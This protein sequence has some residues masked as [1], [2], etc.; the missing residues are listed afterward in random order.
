M[1]ISLDRLRLLLADVYGDVAKVMAG[2]LA[3]NGLRGVTKL[4]VAGF[5]GPRGL[6][7][8]RSV[9]AIFRLGEAL[10][11]FGLHYTVLSMVP[12]ASSREQ[13][14]E[15]DRI[16]KC[17]LLLRV[18]IA[19]AFLLAGAVFAGPIATSILGDPSLAGWVR[20]AFVAVMGQS[21]WKF[22]AGHLSAARE[23]GRVAF[24]Q[25]TTPFLMVGV[26]ATL[27]LAQAFDLTGAIVIYLFA[28]TV[29]VALWFPWVDRRFLRASWNAATTRRVIRFGRWA[30]LSRVSTASLG[31]INPLLLKNPQLSGS[32]AAGET[33]AGLYTFGNELADELTF[34]SESLY[35]VLLPRAGE[36]KSAGA[37][38]GFVTRCY[39]NLALLIVP[40]ILPIFLFKPFLL[41]LG[42]VRVGYLEF[43]PSYE[44][45]VILYASGLL[46]L[47]IIPMRSALYA[48]ELSRV[49][50]Y[51]EAAGAVLLIAGG[52]VLIP[53]YGTIGAAVTALVA[54]ALVLCALLAYGTVQL[55][56]HVTS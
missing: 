31:Q 54:R 35:L 36:K 53:T 33:N 55:R 44:V 45:F 37:L 41:L 49:D 38:R 43:L 40:L 8:L 32:L 27:L 15:A 28:P 6:G 48:L 14:G 10:V 26:T 29:T 4:L 23:F 2:A 25:V 56:R 5:L 11:D 20:L 1:R 7:V 12:A 47:A 13:P 21:L 17:V 51:L 3:R 9:Y 18:L 46:S 39:R 19:T 30:Y 22:V 34:L 52:I 16:L 42:R 50:S 24:Y